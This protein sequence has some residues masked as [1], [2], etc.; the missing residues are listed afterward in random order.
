MCYFFSSAS[1]STNLF[2]DPE[3]V[4]YAYA[5]HDYRQMDPKDQVRLNIIRLEVDRIRIG[6]R[7]LSL[8]VTMS[9]QNNNNN[10][11]NDDIELHPVQPV[12]FPKLS[13]AICFDIINAITHVIGVFCGHVYC[14][15]YFNLCKSLNRRCGVCTRPLGDHYR[16]RLKFNEQEKCVCAFPHCQT[17]FDPQVNCKAIRCGC[18]YCECCF[19]QMTDRCI[20]CNTEL[21]RSNKIVNLVLSYN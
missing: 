6:M 13:C 7:R 11:T 8:I 5:I 10:N 14:S 16:L 20:R 15:R 2:I 4:G 3:L 17:E 9:E 18:V 12:H 1:E 21:G 19:S